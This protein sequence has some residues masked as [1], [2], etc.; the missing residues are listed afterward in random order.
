MAWCVVAWCGIML[1][2]VV[3]CVLCVLCVVLCVVVFYM[4]CDAQ[5]DPAHP[6]E[7]ATARCDQTVSAAD[8]G[9]G[10]V[11]G[12]ARD[13]FDARQDRNTH[14]ARSIRLSLLLFLFVFIQ[15][16]RSTHIWCFFYA[17]SSGHLFFFAFLLLLRVRVLLMYAFVLFCFFVVFSFFLSRVF[18]VCVMSV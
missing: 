14:L 5:R 11:R 10:R 17:F 3:C 1:W 15:V 4:C 2:C 16:N 8:I 6:H 18:N 13:E 9:V 7:A 12:C